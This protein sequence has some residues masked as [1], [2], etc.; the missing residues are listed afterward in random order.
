MWLSWVTNL[1]KGFFLIVIDRVKSVVNVESVY[2]V[3]KVQLKH[4]CSSKLGVSVNSQGVES[5]HSVY[6][7]FKVTINTLA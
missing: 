2:K 1:A 7:V 3:F 5:V 4:L 6:K